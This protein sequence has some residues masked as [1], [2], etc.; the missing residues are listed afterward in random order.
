M[1]VLKH[2]IKRQ[3]ILSNVVKGNNIYSQFQHGLL[4]KFSKFF[5]EK[6]RYI[7]KNR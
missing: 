3:V 7:G 6:V 4:D 2:E 1:I 5:I